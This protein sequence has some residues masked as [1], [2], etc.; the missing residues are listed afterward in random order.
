[1][2]KMFVWGMD[3]NIY[4]GLDKH[5]GLIYGEGKPPSSCSVDKTNPDRLHHSSYLSG[6]DVLFA[7]HIL[8][9]QGIIKT[10]D[11]SSGHY[12]PTKRNYCNFLTYLKYN[13]IDI[14]TI[15]LQNSNGGKWNVSKHCEDT[16]E[17]TKYI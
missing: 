6:E 10:I 7:G 4:S 12:R 11:P 16:N 3:R 2:E 5:L 15:K 8:I 9:K 13:G 17:F 14:T 1:M